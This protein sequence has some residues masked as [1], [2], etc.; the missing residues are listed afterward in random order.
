MGISLNDLNNE[1]KKRGVNDSQSINLLN[2]LESK[3]YIRNEM[4]LFK[5]YI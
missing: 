1:L 5:I 3:N 4:G 2:T